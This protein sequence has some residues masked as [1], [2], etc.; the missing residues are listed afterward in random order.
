MAKTDKNQSVV[1]YLALV[2]KRVTS[3]VFI[4]EPFHLLQRLLILLKQQV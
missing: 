4:D 3:A 2:A 1:P